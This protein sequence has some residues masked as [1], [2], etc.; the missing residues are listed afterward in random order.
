MSSEML[1]GTVYAEFWG[2]E[3]G[4]SIDLH[5]SAGI[6][7]GHA[8]SEIW[9]EGRGAEF[10][11]AAQ[12]LW[13]GL[14]EIFCVLGGWK[15]N[16]V[17]ASRVR[18]RSI[19]DSGNTT[20][21]YEASRRIVPSQRPA[22]TE[23]SDFSAYLGLRDYSLEARG[24]DY[25]VLDLFFDA[26]MRVGEKVEDRKNEPTVLTKLDELRP[27][28]LKPLTD[29]VEGL[30]D[31]R[32]SLQLLPARWDEGDQDHPYRIRVVITD[33]EPDATVTKH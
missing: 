32:V 27:A 16:D 24:A 10:A 7:R 13:P 17:V 26:R 25:D 1:Q 30:I 3:E 5:A 12:T 4:G 14:I 31:E 15:L 33:D 20:Y 8:S 29:L 6:V 22:I 9:R 23:W 21:N 18:A 28:L 19:P 2:D 11:V